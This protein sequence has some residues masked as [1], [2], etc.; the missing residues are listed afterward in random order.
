MSQSHLPP[1][2]PHL[3]SEAP[4]QEGPAASQN[5]APPAEDTAAQK[6]GKEKKP[7]AFGADL[8]GWLQALTF[9]LAFI[10]IFFTF[11]GRV[12]GVDGHSMDPT[13][14]D[15]DM[16]FLQ[17]IAYEP[18]QGDVVVLHKDFGDVE[19]PIVKRVIAVEGQEVE[20]DYD[21]NTVYV[22]GVALDEPYINQE[23]EDVMVERSG[24]VYREFTVP[25]GCIFVMG[26]NRN[27]STDSR[28]AELGMVDTSYVLGRALGVAFPFSHIQSLL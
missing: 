22:D 7:G 21:N 5:P 26:D 2:E 6:A 3:S 23:D 12:I 18:K 9:A 14:N 8:Y 15:R 10:L 17:C 20:I 27:G 13:L 19:T 16:L 28:Y 11:F 4:P 24:M 1:E 25:E